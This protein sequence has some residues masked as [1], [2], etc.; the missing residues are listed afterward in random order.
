MGI[1]DWPRKR[2]FIIVSVLAS[3]IAIFV[4]TTGIVS[5]PDMLSRIQG[6]PENAQGGNGGAE[7]SPSPTGM[8]PSPSADPSPSESAAPSPPETGT[9]RRSE[10]GVTV[11]HGYGID[12][13]ASEEDS[14]DWRYGAGTFDHDFRWVVGVVSVEHKIVPSAP[15]PESCLGTGYSSSIMQSDLPSD[16]VMCV[17]TSEGRFGRI[18][19]T[20]RDPAADSI[21]FDVV[22]WNN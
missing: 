3:I 2:G 8:T 4:F 5:I 7:T 16:T 22:V 13:D 12:L 17:K 15:D 9:I 21:T 20:S 18:T 14:H 10:E 11:F 6:A 1:R 19:F